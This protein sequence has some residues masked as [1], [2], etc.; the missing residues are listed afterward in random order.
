[1]SRIH[2]TINDDN[3]HFKISQ[4]A[5]DRAGVIWDFGVGF[6]I[7]LYKPVGRRRQ[8]RQRKCGRGRSDNFDCIHLL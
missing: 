5:L 3:H 1:M 2:P 8:S 7:N 4:F 6:D